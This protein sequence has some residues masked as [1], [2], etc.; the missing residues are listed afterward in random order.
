MVFGP[1]EDILFVSKSFHLSFFVYPLNSE[2]IYCIGIQG[3][4]RKT[5]DMESE[6]RLPRRWTF[7]V[8]R[9]CYFWGLIRRKRSVSLSVPRRIV[10]SF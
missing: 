6:P 7:M 3:V 4:K 8:V 1:V 2:F 5:E 9:V 10:L